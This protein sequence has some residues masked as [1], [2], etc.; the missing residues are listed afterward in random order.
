MHEEAGARSS[1]FRALNPYGQMWWRTASEGTVELGWLFS[2]NKKAARRIRQTRSTR[3]RREAY[4]RKPLPKICMGMGEVYGS[5]TH[6]RSACAET[7]HLA[8]E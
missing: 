4:S 8:N 5:A 7:W 2:G 3:S 1:R 6:T